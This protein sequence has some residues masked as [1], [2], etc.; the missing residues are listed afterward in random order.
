MASDQHDSPSVI[1]RAARAWRSVLATYHNLDDRTHHLL[2]VAWKLALAGYFVFCAL[3]LT[4]RYVIW[5][6]IEDYKGEIEQVASKAIGNRVAVGSIRAGWDG[7]NPKLLLDQVVVRDKQGRPALTLPAVSATLSWWSIPT[8]SLRFRQLEINGPDL[9]IRR[10][11]TGNVYIAGLLFDSSATQGDGRGADW[12]LSQDEIVIVNGRLRWSDELRKAPELKLEDVRI[13]LQNNGWRHRFLL[14]AKPPAT[15]AAPLDVRADFRHP[16]FASR[17]SNVRE[18][19]GTL[20]ADLQNT[21][22]SAWKAY[23]DYP[24]ELNRGYGSVRAWM[25]LD[26]ARVANFTADLALSDVMARLHADLEPLDLLAVSGRIS[27][28]EDYDPDRA[29]GNSVLGAQGHAVSLVDF[30]L[31]TRDGLTLPETT[32]SEEYTPAR[33]STPEQ[34]V[35]RT[36]Q[37]ELQTIGKFAKYLPLTK[38]LRTVLTEVAPSGQ[39]RDFSVQ[40]QGEYP[41]LVA[42]QVNGEFSGLSLKAQPPRVARPASGKQPAQAAI[43]GIP[44]FENL[45]GRIEANQKGGNVALASE[46]V[47]FYFPGYYQDPAV[48]FASLKMQANWAFLE[49]QKEFQFQIGSM[50]FVHRDIQGSLSGKH[51]RPLDPS[52]KNP[53]TLDLTA[54][55]SGFDVR[56]VGRFL[57]VQMAEAARSWLGSALTAGRARDVMVR[58]KGNLAD[59]PFQPDHPG[60]KRK[61]EFKVTLGLDDVT[62]NYRPDA[63]A[64]DNKSPIWPLAEHINGRATFDGTRMEIHADTAKTMNVDLQNVSAVI[65]DLLAKDMMLEISGGATGALQDFI[66]YTNA[67]PVSDWI[68]DFTADTQATGNAKLQLTFQMPVSHAIDTQVQGALEFQNNDVN[69]IK[70][71]PL[72]ARTRGKLEFKETGFALHGLSAQFLGGTVAIAGGTQANKKFQ[73]TANGNLTAD[74]LRKAFPAL[75]PRVSGSARYALLVN[76][77]SRQPDIIVESNLRGM[78]LDFP[79]P[80]RKAANDAMPLKFQLIDQTPAG[81]NGWRDEIRIA[82]GSAISARYQRQKAAGKGTEWKVVRGGIGINT[83]PPESGSGLAM[84]VVMNTIDADT[85]RGVLGNVVGS[86]HA[87]A[88]EAD[89]DGFALA[90]YVDPDSFSAKTGK[91]TISGMELDQVDLL[92]EH[93]G[94]GWQIGLKSDQATGTVNWVAGAAKQGQDRITAR[95]SALKVSANGASGASDVLAAEGRPTRLPDLDVVVDNFEIYGKKLGRLELGATNAP[96]AAAREWKIDKLVISNPDAVLKATGKWTARRAANV[97]RL[98]YTLDLHNSGKLLDRIGFADTLRDGKGKMDGSLEWKGVPF[99][100][101]KPSLSGRVS[102]ALEKGQFLKAEPGVARLLGVMSLQT[103][104]RRLTLDFRDIFSKG[105]AFDKV[106]ATA[107]IANGTIKTN[108]LKMIGASSSVLM[109]GSADIV[110]ETQNLHVVVMP[111]ISPNVASA[112]YGVVINPVMGIGSILAQLVLRDPLSKILTYEYQIAGSWEQPTITPVKRTDKDKKTSSPKTENSKGAS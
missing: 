81:G 55:L 42:Y 23:F 107:N 2:G 38:N 69:L 25:T 10:D 41:N 82:L 9:D 35:I 64:K 28:R 101:D 102:L 97:T 34:T 75:T 7:L 14:H 12:V 22:L 90:H 57:P 5:P 8:V 98:N 19:R 60:G 68:E 43:P 47:T 87:A 18:W 50:D 61:G 70:G 21:D 106:G 112:V 73:I 105:Y 100:L 58:V 45:T 99:A 16:F 88:P 93:R 62:L 86:K 32:I 27:A 109:E 67:S 51:T 79:A 89:A 33:G 52:D 4:A 17:I 53:G 103:L 56:E 36:R 49:K 96:A 108:N 6:H 80:F 48:L 31:K 1:A 74:G 77:R 29:S 24:F 63:T 104:P 91:L 92:A 84:R 13:A 37:L 94:D 39:L 85:W 20:Y 78:T 30:T 66:R 83:P 59:F 46:N 65:P 40:W 111:D 72:L 95:L 110:N 44:G 76:Q 3:F 54:K 15:L 26:N 11:A 71:L